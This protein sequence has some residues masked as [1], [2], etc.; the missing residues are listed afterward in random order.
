MVHSLIVS[1]PSGTGK[2]TILGKMFEKYPQKFSFSVSATTRA[3]REGEVDGKNYYFLTEEEFNKRLANDEFLE[4]EHVYEGLSYGTLKSEVSRIASEG[5][6]AVFDVD[7]KGGVN[8][9]QKLDDAA[10]AV[11]I[12]PPS[13]ETLKERLEKRG[14]ETPESLAKRINRAEME[15]SY[16]DKFDHIVIN[17]NLDKAIEDFENVLKKYMELK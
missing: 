3:P 2:T 10:L 1:A 12:M 15:I 8:I 16:K 11:F 9:K 7:V 17:D 4:Y 6:I 5:K 13:I 14:T